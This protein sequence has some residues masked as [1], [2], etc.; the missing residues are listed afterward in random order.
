MGCIIKV[1]VAFVFI[2]I[3]V[4][5]LGVLAAMCEHDRNERRHGEANIALSA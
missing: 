2:V 5:L 1:I 3:I 4:V